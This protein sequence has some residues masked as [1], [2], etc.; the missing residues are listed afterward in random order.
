MQLLPHPPSNGALNI[1]DWFLLTQE[2]KSYLHINGYYTEWISKVYTIK[3][4][5]LD[6]VTTQFYDDTIM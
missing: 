6:G 4:V 2:S 5:N 3:Q 1:K